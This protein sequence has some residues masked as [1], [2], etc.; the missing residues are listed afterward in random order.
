MTTAQELIEMRHELEMVMSK[1]EEYDPEQDKA[2]SLTDEGSSY[3]SISAA[4]DDVLPML[5]EPNAHYWAWIRLVKLRLL[6]H[7]F[8]TTP[9][10][11]LPA[12][13]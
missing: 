8:M 10:K 3:V 13:P 2:T 9:F 7:A 6:A 11:V 4:G 5:V 1:H 12:Q